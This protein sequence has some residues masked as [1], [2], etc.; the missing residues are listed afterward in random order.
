M[1]NVKYIINPS[2]KAIF[3]GKFSAAS[4]DD[5]EFEY[6]SDGAADDFP[7]LATLIEIGKANGLKI[8]SKAKKADAI[9]QLNAHL[10]T[11]EINEVNE[12]TDTQKVE[13]II[14]AGL[15]AGQTDDEMLVEIVNQGVSFKSAG[16]LF[17]SVMETKGYRITAKERGEKINDIL[18]GSDFGGEEVTAETIQ[19]A[20]KRITGEVADTSEKQ[21]LNSIRKFAKANEIDLPKVKKGGGGGNSGAMMDKVQEFILSNRDTDIAEIQSKI[22]EWKPEVSE[23]SMNGYTKHTNRMLS[24]LKALTE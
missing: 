9:E 15:E 10:E 5:G 4:T 22:K 3:K 20:V 16:K 24:M 7:A 8:S 14:E 1:N 18:T 12:M 23:G 19:E 11:L 13:E 2:F 21:A 17:K 6:N